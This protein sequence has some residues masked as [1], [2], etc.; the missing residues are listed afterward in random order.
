MSAPC[1][2]GRCRAGVA[3]VLST[4][5]KTSALR[6]S[7]ATSANVDDTKIRIG[8]RLKIKEPRLLA[9]GIGYGLRAR[10]VSHRHLDAETRQSLGEERKAIAAK[11]PV[12]DDVIPRR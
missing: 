10:E 11:H 9:D 2:I 5:V 12:D 4:T 1:S 3:K 8:W 6:A 7:D